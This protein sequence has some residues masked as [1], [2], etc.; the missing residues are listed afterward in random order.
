MHDL[1]EQRLKE[2]LQ[3]LDRMDIKKSLFLKEVLQQVMED[4]R[5]I[6]LTSQDLL[7]HHCPRHQRRRNKQPRHMIHWSARGKNDYYQICWDICM[8][9]EFSAA[10]ADYIS[11]R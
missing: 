8:E 2:L 1:L 5:Q 11:D 7:H 3:V 10:A 6:P 9:W 4:I